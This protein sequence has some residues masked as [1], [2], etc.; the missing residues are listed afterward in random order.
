MENRKSL[1]DTN[2]QGTTVTRQI[3]DSRMKVYHVLETRE[4]I[5]RHQQVKLNYTQ[6]HNKNQNQTLSPLERQLNTS[7]CQFETKARTKT[8]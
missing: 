3:K 1:E 8:P 4:T 5:T 6:K 2:T 7:N